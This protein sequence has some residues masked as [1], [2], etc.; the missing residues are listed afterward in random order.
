MSCDVLPGW[1]SIE[2]PAYSK[3][4][5]RWCWT[6][7]FTCGSFITVMCYSCVQQE[8][9]S[10]MPYC[11]WLRQ[12]CI[13]LKSPCL[14]RILG[15]L[16]RTF[17]ATNSFACIRNKKEFIHFLGSL[18]TALQF[19]DLE[20]SLDERYKSLNKSSIEQRNSPMECQMTHKKAIKTKLTNLFW[21]SFI[22]NLDSITIPLFVPLLLS[23]L[24]VFTTVQVHFFSN[25][26]I[27]STSVNIWIFH[28]M[29]VK[30]N[31]Y[32]VILL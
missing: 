9:I 8:P 26:R 32:T 27:T 31:H 2:L 19:S 30:L 18:P 28:V 13:S 16:L 14:Y 6:L 17:S 21:I 12:N 3:I 11:M 23:M 15:L 24:Q 20:T 22:Q 5:P 7:S 29:H 10:V 1:C 25:Y 4:S